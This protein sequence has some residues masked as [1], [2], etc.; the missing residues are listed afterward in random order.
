MEAV[1]G[2]G[3]FSTEYATRQTTRLQNGKF[4]G[5]F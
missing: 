2:Y 4:F 1:K 3:F 5:Q